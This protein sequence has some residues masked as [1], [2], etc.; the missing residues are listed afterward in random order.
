LKRFGRIALLILGVQLITT[1]V[2]GEEIDVYSWPLREERSRDYDVLH[3]RIELSFEE[4]T[5]SFSGET[6]ISLASLK[7]GLASCDLD[8]ETFVVESVLDDASHRLEFEQSPGRLSVLL[9]EPLGYRETTSFTVSYSATGV[10]V[11]AEKYGLSADYDLGLDFKPRTSENPQL[12]NTL[13]WPEGARHW[14]PCYDHPNDRATQEVIATVREEYKVLSNGKLVSVTNGPEPGT[15]RWHWSQEKTH[16][17]YLSVLVAGPYTIIEDS[18]GD[19][20]INYWVYEEDEDNAL[21]SFWKTPAIIHFF[22]KEF[23]YEYPW[24]KYDQITIPGIGGGTECTSATVLGQST[25]HD[26]RA[27]QDF[28]S[29]GLVAHEAAHQWWGDLVTYRAW[30]E[31]WISESFATYSEYLFTRNDLGEDEGAVNLLA[32]KNAYLREAQR[33][34]RPVVFDR[35]RYPDDNFDAHTYPKGAVILNMLRWI[36]G[37]SAF[38][39][40]IAHFLHK[41]AFQPVDTYDLMKSIKEATGQ[42]LDWFFEQWIFRPGHPVFEVSSRWDESNNKLSLNIRQTQD[43]SKAIPV[44]RTPVVIGI[45]TQHGKI[46]ERFWLENKEEILGIDLE[47]EPLLVRFD[48]GNYLLKEWTFRK[49]IDELLYQ[50]KSDDVIGRMWAAG[51]L[52]SHG[53]DS[54]ALEALTAASREDPF[55]GVRRS[56]IQAV[57]EIDGKGQLSFF[58]KKALDENSKVRVAALQ[59]LGEVGDSGLLEFFA[60]R[61]VEDDSYLVQA[62]ALRSIGKTDP[63][64]ARE[65]LQSATGMK[66]PR[67]V[68]RSAATDALRRIKE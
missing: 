12:I 23:G 62:E 38:R 7:E 32:K 9:S 5:R 30:R 48:E 46:L 66:S 64:S 54:R 29:H 53:G 16:P 41:H 61:F 63:G 31:T 42:N 52:A 67:D 58:R 18:L 45:H 51:E 68:I 65:L 17:T 8:A 19:L 2:E 15:R 22:N 50:L 37:D 49:S 4:D 13:S 20:P 57:A 21:R 3:Y 28:P 6:T 55:W 27:E 1:P 39:E 35:W 44:Y 59:A 36:M 26:E 40:T 56:A 47:E 10:D 24:E 11:D 14:F 25:I 60:N 33:Y 34:M 43:T